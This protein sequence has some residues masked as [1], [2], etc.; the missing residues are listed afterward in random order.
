MVVGNLQKLSL[1]DSSRRPGRDEVKQEEKRRHINR[2][3]AFPQS[4]ELF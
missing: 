2:S 3:S 4:G 1:Y